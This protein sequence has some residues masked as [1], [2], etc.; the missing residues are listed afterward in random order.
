LPGGQMRLILALI[1]VLVTI[2]I[3]TGS[4]GSQKVVHASEVLANLSADKPAEYDNCVITGPLDLSQGE[5][6]EDVHFNNTI[7]QDSVQF[8]STRFNSRVYFIS[9]KFNNSANFD[10]S[11]FNSTAVF[12]GSNFNSDI[13]FVRSRFNGDAYFGSTFNS[14]VNF[15]DSKFNSIARFWGS[16]FNNTADFDDSE[17]NSTADFVATWF[18]STPSFIGSKFNGLANFEDSKFNKS[19]DFSKANFN[20]DATFMDSNFYGTADFKGSN[21]NSSTEYWYS[22]FYGYADFSES[23]FNSDVSFTGSKFDRGVSFAGSKFKSKALFY[24]AV[25]KG[26]IDLTS[27][28]YDTGKLY[29]TWDENYQLVYDPLA[30]QLLIEDLKKQGFMPDADICYYQFRVAQFLHHFSLNPY[31]DPFI[32][33][34]DLGAWVFYGYGKK[35]IYPLI[36]SLF[37]VLLFGLF[38]RWVG[39]GTNEWPPVARSMNENLWSKALIFSVTVFLSGTKLFVD[40]PDM[41]SLQGRS[42]SMMKKA[43]TVERVLGGFFSILFFLAI[44][45]TVVR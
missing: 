30:Y 15:K 4:E 13:S 28:E 45:A 12:E 39:L 11:Q 20:N 8:N 10:A 14:I 43:F 18:K 41:P 24:V 19:A 32:D 5:V 44:G 6:N 3:V 38:W 36:W 40:P 31:G 22:N 2:M 27:T 26:T 34:A 16:V 29:I 37:V 17:F 35:P 1:L 33:I 42:E 21:F 9:S 25:F 23:N 7:F